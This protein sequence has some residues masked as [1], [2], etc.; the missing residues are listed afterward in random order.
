M[1]PGVD[2]RSL[3]LIDEQKR[4]QVM[5]IEET[6]K[7]SLFA[8]DQL[9]LAEVDRARLVGE[10]TA[11]AEL[12]RKTALNEAVARSNELYDSVARIREELLKSGQAVRDGMVKALADAQSRVDALTGTMGRG[13]DVEAALKTSPGL[14]SSIL[15]KEGGATLYERQ[16][17]GELEKR[18]DI[19]VPQSIREEY[20]K[21]AIV[22]DLG[23]QADIRQA[24]KNA[25]EDG[26]TRLTGIEPSIVPRMQSGGI[27]PGPRGRS[28]PI[29]A[30]G[31]E[32]V[33]NES[34]QA[35]LLHGRAGSN[36]VTIEIRLDGRV[37]G[38]ST[39]TTIEKLISVGRLIV[40]GR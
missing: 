28:T 38:E 14:G 2:P 24:I 7:K 22:G 6:L 33:L 23:K 18:F 10:A 17:L 29:I 13:T 1:L 20:F 34:Q 32:V 3:Q 9:K 19:R 26:T 4:A 21:A 39:C 36:P 11:A 12:A 16:V 15:Y 25:A 31:G 35:S 37:I 27:V 30:H 8:I 5:G 40:Q